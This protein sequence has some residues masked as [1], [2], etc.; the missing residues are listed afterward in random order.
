MRR[1]FVSGRKTEE[2]VSVF[3]CYVIRYQQQGYLSGETKSRIYATKREQ[4]VV[5]TSSF[6]QG[7]FSSL[8][9]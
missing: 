8:F 2:Q 6:L 7:R 5:F 4:Q 1:L 3:L 9:F